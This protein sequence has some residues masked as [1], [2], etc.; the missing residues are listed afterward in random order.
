MGTSRPTLTALLTA[1]LLAAGIGAVAVPQAQAAARDGGCDAGE[2]C[3]YYNSGQGGSISDFTTSISDY[4]ATQPSCYDFKGAGAGQGL[5]VKNN[6]A[7]VWNRTGKAVTVFFNSGYGGASQTIAAGAKADLNATLKNQN[8]SHRIGAATGSVA[9]IDVSHYQGTVD[10]GAQYSAGVRWAY[11]KATEGSSYIDP[12]FATNY[13][14]ARNKGIIRGAYHFANPG[15]ASGKAQAD[16]FI[17][18]GGGWKADGYTLPGA[19]DLEAGCY[20][21]TDA[22]MVAW[23]KDFVAQYKTRT[24][25]APVIY[26]TTS[27]WKDCTGNST[28]FGGTPLWI[29]R[30]NG[31]TTPDELP[32]SWSRWTMWQYTSSPLDKDKF[33]GTLAALKNF[34]NNT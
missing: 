30:Y 34:A 4:G 7:S 28:A 13:A 33:N 32:A 31:A 6:A 19:L 21:K 17:A 15:G 24:G 26:T 12:K 23:I 20:G 10:W 22:A 2:F 25:R 8:A 3:Y 16:Y 5:C 29:A 27:W 9:G 18:H 14:G 11:V 1:P